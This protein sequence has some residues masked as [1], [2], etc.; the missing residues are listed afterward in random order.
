M[1]QALDRGRAILDGLPY[2]QRT[3]H[4][5]VVDPEKWDFYAMDAC[6]MAGDD[7]AAAEYARAVLSRGTGVDGVDRWPM[8]MAEARL[9]LAVVAARSGNL[10]QARDL[11][12]A[13]LGGDRQSLPSLLMVAGEL[14]GELE[15]R[16]P[17]EGATEE[18][19]AAIRALR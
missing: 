18:F 5:F 9:T 6:R 11:G 4:H 15:R 17:N 10:E 8:R 14:D 13:A 7:Q 12:V 19:R 1:H 16:Y 3:E 2:P